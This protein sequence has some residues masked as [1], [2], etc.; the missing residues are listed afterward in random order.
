MLEKL[1][2]DKLYKFLT[3][4]G[5][6]IIVTTFTVNE[7]KNE[8][9]DTLHDNYLIKANSLISFYYTHSNMV[10]ARMK[11]DKNGDLLDSLK[12][13]EMERDTFLKYNMQ[14]LE[15]VTH[16]MDS[17]IKEHAQFKAIAEDKERELK[18]LREKL[19]LTSKSFL[20]W[21]EMHLILNI[22]GM[23]FFLFGIW[24]WFNNDHPTITKVSTKRK[25]AK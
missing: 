24:F 18:T 21:K 11:I 16:L 3:V 8:R 23:I 13:S 4:L 10:E 1:P 14:K 7:T 6:V 25:K 20:I 22:L 2:T 17:S 12:F 19:S 9:I 15:S 5:L